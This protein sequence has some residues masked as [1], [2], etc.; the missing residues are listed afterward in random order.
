MQSHSQFWWECTSPRD[1]RLRTGC[2][3]YTRLWGCL[4]WSVEGKED[5]LR[6][7]GRET[8]PGST[9]MA[10]TEVDSLSV[11]F[12]CRESHFPP[13]FMF[14]FIV[15]TWS[16]E[17]DAHLGITFS[18]PSD[19]RW[20]HITTCQRMQVHLTCGVCPVLIRLF[21]T[22]EY[23]CFVHS[24]MTGKERT[25]LPSPPAIKSMYWRWQSISL[26]FWTNAKHNMRKEFLLCL[27]YF[28]FREACLFL[29]LSSS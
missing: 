12:Y 8:W 26:S 11:L 4:S 2:R 27:T 23:F 5:V 18:S 21:K 29:F 7:M 20:D 28:A 16:W 1:A 13:K 24:L 22:Q 6:W 15:H 14:P 19:T 9:R 25:I 3:T 17:R 10:K